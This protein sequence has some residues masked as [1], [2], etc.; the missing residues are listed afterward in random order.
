MENILNILQIATPKFCDKNGQI[1]FFVYSDNVKFC[2]PP[3][4]PRIVNA[5]FRIAFLMTGLY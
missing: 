4:P 3:P 5:E 1:F 2:L